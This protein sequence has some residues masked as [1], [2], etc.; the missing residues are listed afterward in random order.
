[1]G[2]Y[3]VQHHH[4][5]RPRGRWRRRSWPSIVTVIVIVPAIVT[6]GSLTLHICIPRPRLNILRLPRARDNRC[7]RRRR[8]LCLRR[9]V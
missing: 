9:L 4:V 8:S 6:A 3:L 2:N 5:H 7:L 1:M